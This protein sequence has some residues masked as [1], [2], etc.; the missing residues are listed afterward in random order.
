MKNIVCLLIF[1]LG[2]IVSFLGFAQVEERSFTVVNPA[3]TSNFPTLKVIIQM[4]KNEQPLEADFKLFDYD[5]NP[6]EQFTLRPVAGEDAATSGNVIF[7]LIDASSNV[8]DIPLLNFKKAV[9][10]SI[11]DFITESDVVNVGYFNVPNGD[12]RVLK[13]LDFE[14]NRNFSKIQNQ[15]QDRITTSLR[16]DSTS[17]NYAFKAI[18]EALKMM[19]DSP[20]EGRQI[21][22]VLSGASDNQDTNFTADD[23]IDMAENKDISIHT[24]NVKVD[25]SF[26]PDRFE[27]LSLRT[28]G[29]SET[30]RN[31]SDIKKSIGDILETRTESET[32]V[33]QQYD[34]TFSVQAPADGKEYQ[35]TINYKSEPP[36]VVNYTT[37][38]EGGEVDSGGNGI[39]NGYGMLIALL[40]A[41]VLLGVG[42]WY[43]NEMKIR[44]QEAE[45]AEEE[46]REQQEEERRR[47]Q[48]EKHSAVEELKEKNIR[49]QE[50]LKAKEDE[51]NRKELEMA[52]KPMMPPPP[53]KRDLKNTIISGGGGAPVLKIV[54]GNFSHNFTLNKPT[55]TIGRAANND[56][57]IPE[58]TVSSKHATITIQK[59]SF[60]LTDLGSTNGTFV[61][62]SRI[63]SKMLK[64][65]DLIKLGAAQCKFEI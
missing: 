2:M 61:N 63:E 21:L 49:L 60:F 9:I 43:A 41:G 18:K 4:S 25:D 5:Q 65:G 26:S 57:V 33:L 3:D 55:I 35:Y 36:L 48:E 15:I 40:S 28:N 7:F 8:E 51:M 47:L 37:P 58:Q 42:Y 44:R 45:E 54:T 19:S 53:E 13:A 20:D 32:P 34:L 62:G 22:I 64:S 27:K 46:F 17:K 10:E 56:I 11:D 6:I 52:N 39:F 23:L 12:S 14:F 24:I 1:F 38:G 31:F 29:R 59:G 30:A 16:G 50:Q